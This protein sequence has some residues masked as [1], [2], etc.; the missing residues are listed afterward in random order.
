MTSAT[1]NLWAIEDFDRAV[2]KAHWRDWLSWLFKR[3]NNLISFD[4]IR[5]TLSFKRQRYLGLQIV[6]LR[7]I[8]GSEGRHRD[9][10]RAFYPRQPYVKDR[11]M[12][13][14]KAHYAEVS[15]P[16]VELFKID[17]VY[18]VRDGNHRISVARAR[19]Q[20][21]IDAYVTEIKKTL[22]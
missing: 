3:N 5:Q 10:D 9:F 7:N 13:I 21:F 2:S 6:P 15:L 19:G 16:P 11:W 17:G 22:H 8:V 14:D 4:E 20:Q 1:F 12:S 18:F